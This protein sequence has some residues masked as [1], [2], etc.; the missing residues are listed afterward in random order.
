MGYVLQKLNDAI[1]KKYSPQHSNDDK[2]LSV[3]I[4]IKFG[5][6]ALLE[7]IHRA[8]GFPSVSTAY[9]LLNAEKVLI[10]SHTSMPADTILKKC[11]ENL[12]SSGF[13]QDGFHLW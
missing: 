2:E 5:G 8:K 7:I 9:R 3:I 4:I 13:I 11:L 1:E 10:D 12:N 6:P